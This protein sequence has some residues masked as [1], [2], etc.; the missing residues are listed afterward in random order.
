MGRRKRRS[1]VESRAL[2]GLR[3]VLHREGEKVRAA[4]QRRA[5]TQKELGR[6]A[7]VHQTTISRVERGEGGTLSLAAWQ[8]IADALEL[9]LDLKLGRD[10]REDTRDAGHLAV[11]ELVMRLGRQAGYGRTFEL[12]TRPSDP[13]GWV[14]VGLVDHARCRL[15]LVECCNLMGDIGA[16]TRS[17]DRKAAE[18]AGLAVALGGEGDPYSVHV[19]WVIRDTR[20]NRE[21]VRRYPELFTSRFP[22]PSRR[23]IQ[24]LT[25]GS[26]PPS[27]RGLVWC[28]VRATRLFAWR[29]P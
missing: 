16:S 20:R 14:D 26:E 6:R 27:G 8:R 25:T 17:S 18:A 12:T 28:D 22:G 15:T 24:A 5:W 1:K 2:R 21:L 10:A 13:T 9:P 23:W 4:R 7:R 29:R 3:L 19:C 11:Q